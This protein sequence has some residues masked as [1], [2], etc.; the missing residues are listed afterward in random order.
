[1]F[2]LKEI[3]EI[4]DKFGKAE[5]LIQYLKALRSIGIIQQDSFITDGHSEYYGINGRAVTSQPVH[6]TLIVADLS[7]REGLLKQL[8]LHKQHKT[9]YL[10]MS[11]GLADSGVEKWT[12][13]TIDMTITYYDKDGTKLETESIRSDET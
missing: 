3:N 12:F 5:T 4:H 1:M 8:D 6:A 13:D 10:E 2:T 11:K 9:T 7:D